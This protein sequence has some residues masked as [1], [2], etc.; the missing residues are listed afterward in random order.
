[1]APPAPVTAATWPASGG[2][3]G[4]AELGLLQ[5]PVLALEHVGSPIDWNA[6]DRLGVGDDG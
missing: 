1:M 3:L 2:S 4:R 5:R 6:P